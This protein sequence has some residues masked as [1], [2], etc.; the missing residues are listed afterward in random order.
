MWNFSTTINGRGFRVLHVTPAKSTAFI[1]RL[2]ECIDG[3]VNAIAFPLSGQVDGVEHNQ[4]H[5]IHV[6]FRGNRTPS[7]LTADISLAAMTDDVDY[8]CISAKG[9]WQVTGD[10]YTY[11]DQE[12]G[13]IDTEYLLIADGDIEIDGTTHT[14]TK[15]VKLSETKTI[16]SIG[17]SIIIPFDVI[18]LG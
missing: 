9:G 5:D 12:E 2:S 1:H 10:L 4:T 15:I 17:E 8:Y 13:T 6:M 14:G 11:T 16:K 18:E 3:T 7:T